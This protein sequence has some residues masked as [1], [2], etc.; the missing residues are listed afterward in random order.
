MDI[1]HH[2]FRCLSSWKQND[3]E[4]RT[5]TTLNTPIDECKPLIP[6]TGAEPGAG[7]SGDC[8]LPEQKRQNSRGDGATKSVT[9]VAGSEEDEHPPFCSPGPAC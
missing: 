5:P 8:P 6:M 1:D 3:H 7:C 4:L 2:R 9:V